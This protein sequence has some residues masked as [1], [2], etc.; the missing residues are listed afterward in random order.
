[1]RVE[2]FLGL[3]AVAVIADPTAS[4]GAMKATEM[5]SLAKLAGAPTLDNLPFSNVTQP[6][7]EKTAAEIV[8]EDPK[9]I[10]VGRD[11]ES[12]SFSV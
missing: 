4:D 6:T 12:V 8:A 9:A 7:Y 3:L 10:F 2:L 11:V 1:M 5:D